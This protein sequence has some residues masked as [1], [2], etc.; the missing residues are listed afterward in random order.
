MAIPAFDGILNVLPPH[1][2]DPTNPSDLSPYTCTMVELCGRFNTS[3][4]RKRILLGLLDLRAELYLLDFR[5]FQWLSGSFV[6]NIEIHERRDPNDVDTI[7]IAETP[8]L[9]KIKS[10][11]GLDQT[12][13]F[14]LKRKPNT[15]SIIMWYHWTRRHWKS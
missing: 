9:Q 4:A 1:S 5:G 2:G 14:P 15:S 6:E 10:L 12:C 8:D 11:W 13:S 7:T 3:A